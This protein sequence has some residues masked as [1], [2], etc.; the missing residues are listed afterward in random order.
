MWQNAFARLTSDPARGDRGRRRRLFGVNGASRRRGSDGRGRLGLGG[1]GGGGSL[2]LVRET[3]RD[4][5]Q[6]GLG[7]VE[8]V[9][10]AD[11]EGHGLV[12]RRSVRNTGGDVLVDALHDNIFAAVRRRGDERSREELGRETDD[13]LRVLRVGAACA[14]TTVLYRKGRKK[15]RRSALR[16]TARRSGRARNAR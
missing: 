2:G 12:E 4:G 1:L 6:V 13:E 14:G 8:G 5:G 3:P 15:S 7:R 9:P 10:G 11:G 16:T